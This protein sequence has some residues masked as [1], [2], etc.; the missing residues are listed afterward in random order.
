VA[1]LGDFLPDYS[2]GE[3]DVYQRS[4]VL[5]FEARSRGFREAYP[6]IVGVERVHITAIGSS[7]PGVDSYLAQSM[8]ARQVAHQFW[9]QR[10][11]VAS[12]RDTWIGPALAD[13]YAGFYLHAAF[14]S[15][16]YEERI[17]SQLESIENPT[18]HALNQNS[19]NRTYRPLSLTGATD[20]SEISSKL[21]ADYGA[22]LAAD[23]IRLRIGDDAYFR[24]MDRLARQIG[25]TSRSRLTTDDLQAAFEYTSGQDLSDFFDYW[26]HGGFI[27]EISVELSRVEGAESGLHGCIRSNVP[28]GRID[29]PVEVVDQG[30]D[31]RVAALIDVVDGE[32]AFWV[33]DRTE[34]ARVELDPDGFTPAY[35]RE[36][37][38]VKRPR[39]TLP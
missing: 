30:G 35:R 29:I 2:L 24:A 6:G 18:E 39:C 20:L 1:W 38:W 27:P 19:I 8:I 16:V 28:F 34:D 32:G 10:I 7:I 14:G 31:R 9:G 3:I 23:M 26:I 33:P 21:L 15:E 17:S 11:A 12:G 4:S 13:A 22:Y 25:S 36:L 5:A 37:S